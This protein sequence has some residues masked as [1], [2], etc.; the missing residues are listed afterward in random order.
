VITAAS[1]PFSLPGPTN[2]QPSLPR[3]RMRVSMVVS[4]I[5]ALLAVEGAHSPPPPFCCCM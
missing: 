4:F 3:P 1:L 5:T 2:H